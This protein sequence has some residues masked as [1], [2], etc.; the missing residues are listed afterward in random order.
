MHNILN[1]IYIKRFRSFPNC[2]VDLNTNPL[3]IVG[4]NGAGKT[5]FTD[6]FS[7]MADCM[8]LQLQATFDKRGG[9]VSV[10]NKISNRSYPANLGLGFEFGNINRS[11]A[12]GRYAF[13]VKALPS[14]GFKVVHEQCIIRTKDN[15]RHWFDRKS[16]FNT[17]IPGLKPA[18]D[19]TALCLPI[20][21][22]DD[23]FAPV[24]RLFSGMRRYQIEPSRLRE[25]QDPDQGTYL[26]SDGSNTAS[27]L[28]ELIRAKNNSKIN[29]IFEY[30]KHI[31]PNTSSVQPKKHGNKL[32]MEF[33]QSWQN[34]GGL[35]F[36]AYNMSDGTLR[37]IGLLMS[38]FQ[39]P[40][41]SVLVVEEPEATIHPGA[42]G[43]ILDLLKEA[44]SMMQVIV[45]SHSPELLDAE[46]IQDDNIRIVS[47]T[48]GVSG[49]YPL[50]DASRKAIKEHL[51]GAGELL[52]ANALEHAAKA[53]I[54]CDQTTL[55]N[56]DLFEA[57][58]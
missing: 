7:F 35:K 27:V 38:V 34:K 43:A 39:Q 45:T 22:G 42:L 21:G 15:K 23:R 28:Q 54:F 9:I 4:R 31:V 41:P 55:Q 56:G 24:F 57:L 20:V 49:I 58:Q 44:A 17:N 3:F 33:K 5:N 8:T 10:R 50:A 48:E 53:N 30:L 6:I 12:G 46:W 26:K 11:I 16:D 25:M 40:K 32:T 14:Y 47:W 1:K 37:T 13:E 51:M 52:R 29:D 19:P 36:E 18:L 2:I